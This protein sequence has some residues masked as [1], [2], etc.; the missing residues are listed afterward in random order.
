MRQIRSLLFIIAA[1]LLLTACKKN[2]AADVEAGTPYDDSETVNAS[3][4]GI[5]VNENNVPVTGATVQLGALTVTT[6]ANGRFSF[7]HKLI[8]KNNGYVKV[9]KAGYFNGNRSFVTTAGRTH[10]LRIKL[11]PKTITGTI[12]AANGGTVSLAG[13]GKVTLTAGSITD[14]AGVAYTGIINVAMTWIDPTAS[15]LASTIQGDLRGITTAG[16][17]RVLATYGMLG[18]ELTSASGQPLKVGN[19]KTAEIILPIPAALQAKAPATITLCHFDEAKGRWIQEGSATKT[20]SNYVG[21]VSHFSFWSYDILFPLVQ[22]CVH[23]LSQGNQPL[24]GITIAIRLASN[25]ITVSYGM[26]DSLGNVCGGVPLNEALILEVLSQCGSVLYTQPVGPFAANASV[27]VNA[28]NVAMTLTGTIV[29]CSNVPVTNGTAIVNTSGGYFYNVSTNSS[30]AFTLVIP[31]CNTASYSVLPVDNSTL[32]Q[33]VLITATATG[34]VVNLGNLQACGANTQ[35]YMH[36][37]IDGIPYNFTSPVDTLICESGPN[38]SN[39]YQFLSNVRGF[40]AAP[41]NPGSG[42][43]GAVIVFFHNN[44]VGAYAIENL[45]IY[46]PSSS[47]GL[48]SSKIVSANPQINITAL[49]LPVTGFIE[50]NY[51]VVMEFQFGNVITNRNVVCN[52][53]V[54]RPQ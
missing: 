7:Q 14:A 3:V 53:R 32:Q 25:P 27:T 43:D 39:P 1:M 51:S 4:E 13:G 28:S 29:N 6:T 19:G 54:R 49:G 18:V 11:M 2:D 10:I 48:A 45:S 16:T 44:N 9:A 20:G 50:G 47:Q 15:D 46:L 42:I 34:G 41:N 23:A 17:E 12:N 35:E 26:T 22:L 38:N 24:P 8:S 5:V 52:F 40:R 33:G 31:Y 21:T 36:L 37:L 30:G